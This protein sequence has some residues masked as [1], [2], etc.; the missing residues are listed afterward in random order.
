[1]SKSIRQNL[2]LAFVAAAAVAMAAPAARAEILYFESVLEPENEVPPANSPGGG[3][4]NF[5]YDT[6][7]RMFSWTVT[8]AMLTGPVTGA[9]IHGPAEP[10]Q[11]A[12]VLIPFPAVATPITGSMTLT[13]AQAADMMAGKW[14]V[15]IHTAANPGGEVRGVIEK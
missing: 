6:T 2:A 15:N 9:H 1:M 4:A 3:L 11:N 8:Y 7:T 14:Y 13:P 5:A 10:G 12:G